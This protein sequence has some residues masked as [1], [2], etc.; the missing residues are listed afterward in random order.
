MKIS[1]IIPA[2]NC[3]KTLKNTLESI[4]NQ[5]YKNF[6][7]IIINDGSIDG[8]KK[9][10]NEYQ[11]KDKRVIVYHNEN[12]GVSYSRN[13]GI[14]K[15]TGDF[16]TFVD[17][18][19]TLE[20]DCYE[21]LLK[22]MKQSYD[23]IRYNFKT[24]GGK[25]FDNKM[26]DLSKRA[27]EL[28]KGNSINLLMKHFL[29]YTEE[30]LPNLVM[31]LLIKKEIIDKIKFNVDLRMMEDVEFYLKLFLEAKSGYFIDMKKYN[32]F[33]NPNSVTHNKN[34]FEKNIFGILDTNEAISKICK[35]NNFDEYIPYINFNHLRIISEILMNSYF[36]D[37]SIFSDIVRNLQKNKKFKQ[38]ISNKKGKVKLK[39]YFIVLLLKYNFIFG[40]KIYLCCLKLLYKLK[41]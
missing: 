14:S 28:K 20:L 11:K 34:N 21:S 26:Y 40:L 13:Y 33:V 5:T 38:M 4:L 30:Q 22:Y 2:Y 19:D 32:Y 15:S 7:V 41:K 16:I 27:V 8:T 6:E 31:L 39:N 29:I 12:H 24:I 36:Y 25:S 23:F 35:S 3:E 1:I 9:I 37:K 18:D 17:S 10:C